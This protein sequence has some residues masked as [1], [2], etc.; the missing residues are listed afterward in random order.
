MKF[1]KAPESNVGWFDSADWVVQLVVL[2]VMVLV[3]AILA[4]RMALRTRGGDRS[5][6]RQAE[7]PN[8]ARSN[9][10]WQRDAQSGHSLERWRCKNCGVDAF[11][12]TGKPPK[13]CKR[14]LKVA[15][16]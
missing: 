9:C 13:E 3:L 1:V 6:S 8:L 10:R 7:V 12:A 15:R 2:S 5:T 14:Q 4:L 11:T 16:L